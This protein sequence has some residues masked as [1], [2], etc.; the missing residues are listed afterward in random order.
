MAAIILLSGLGGKVRASSEHDE[1]I[2]VLLADGNAKAGYMVGC[3][4]TDI[5]IDLCDD[6]GT[7]DNFVGICLP[8][9]DTDV[10]T[11]FTAGDL[12][13]VIRPKSGHL[14][15]VLIEDP[16]ATLQE[17]HPMAIGDTPGALKK[18]AAIG[19]AETIQII[20][21]I[22]EPVITGTTFATVWWG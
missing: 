5:T 2:T 20:A 4:G 12:V 13:E 17:G 9:Y 18:E 8:R 16:Q 19:G 7:V 11:A 22:A 21:Q 6:D 3:E 10:D 14:Y 1:I 15:N